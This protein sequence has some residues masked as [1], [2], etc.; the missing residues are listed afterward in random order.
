MRLAPLFVLAA[1]ALT[2]PA[3]AKPKRKAAPKPA[4]PITA[5]QVHVV[6]VADG[7]RADLAFDGALLGWAVPLAHNHTRDLFLL[8]GERS[9]ASVAASPPC[10][11]RNSKDAGDEHARLYRWRAA[12]PDRLEL[13]AADLPSGTLDAA[14][15]D[16]DGE[17]ECLLLREGRIEL[18]TTS[19]GS[20]GR[21][22][23]LVTDA[24][25]GAPCCS[26]RIASED[27][28]PEDTA[29]RIP[30]PGVF[31]TY[32]SGKDGLVKLVSEQAIP[33]R[34]SAGADSVAV[35]S[36]VVH[37]IGRGSSGRMLFATEP[38]ALGKRRLRTM[39]LDPDSP[40]EP[41]AEERLVM[42][43]DAE[44]VV[45]SAF[46]IFDG[47]PVLV[48]TTT[49]ADKLSLLGEKALRV[50]PLNGDRTRAGNEPLFAAKTDINLW[51]AA[52]PALVDLDRD[53]HQ[54]LVLSYWKGLTNTI[55]AQETYR[56]GATGIFAKAH[57]TSFD[58]E[59]GDR[60]SMHFGE[61]MDGDGRPDLVLLANKELLVFPGNPA[62]RAAE[63]PVQSVP[64]RRLALP[65][66]LPGA[67]HTYVSMGLEGV[68]MGRSSGGAGTPHFLD[69]DGD[70]RPEAVFAGNGE[71]GSRVVVVFVRGSSP[72]PPS[73]TVDRH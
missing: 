69:L 14:D 32:R 15:L 56:G 71:S 24:E 57:T 11:V 4:A 48:V 33:A 31:Q 7:W 39:L 44:R 23:A 41:R 68:S 50:Y 54:D 10:G 1:L 28:A 60:G 63:K 8:V 38:E 5:P 37:P 35:V 26:P 67:G 29:L 27:A 16:G 45:D 12:A 61:D 52:T 21:T 22:R 36:P 53:G 51:Q 25:L 17:E 42:F 65:A 59:N 64:S 30:L 13:I 62:D 66:D 72:S 9:E 19:P 70:G 73:A 34:L 40:E 58:V 20:A 43:P 2:S 6:R 55:A 49:A 3:I 47:A 18:V 46:L